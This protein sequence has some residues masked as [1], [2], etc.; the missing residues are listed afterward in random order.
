MNY[1]ERDKAMYELYIAGM[2]QVEIAGQYSMAKQNAGLIIR[3]YAKANK[4]PLP[5]RN[6]WKAKLEKQKRRS[7]GEV[8]SELVQLEH[9]IA[10]AASTVVEHM[11]PSEVEHVKYN[12][13]PHHRQREVRTIVG[14]IRAIDDDRLRTLSR[15]LRMPTGLAH[16]V[17]ISF[18]VGNIVSLE[19][20]PDNNTLKSIV[21]V[22]EEGYSNEI[23]P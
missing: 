17:R 1:A 23:S 3:K 22:R 13:L 16:N 12:G 21:L 10:R 7:T 9:D 6:N 20:W 5:V 2:T 11:P 4:L 15:S 19:Y 18:S 14:T 8:I